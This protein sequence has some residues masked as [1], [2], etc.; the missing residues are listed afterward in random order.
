MELS[1]TSRSSDLGGSYGRRFQSSA[2]PSLPCGDA[3][4]SRL[5][6]PR[7]AE[8]LPPPARAPATSRQSPGLQRELSPPGMKPDL[9]QS[10]SVQRAAAPPAP[11]PRRDPAAPGA[12]P[13]RRTHPLA[14]GNGDPSKRVA[15]AAG[16]GRQSQTPVFVQRAPKFFPLAPRKVPFPR[17]PKPR[18]SS[19]R[20]WI[21]YKRRVLWGWFLEGE[22]TC[23]SSA[24]LEPAQVHL[25]SPH[26]ATCRAVTSSSPGPPAPTTGPGR[27]PHP[28]VGGSPRVTP[29]LHS[30]GRVVPAVPAPAPILRALGVLEGPPV[31]TAT[32]PA[33]ETGAVRPRHP[34]RGPAAPVPAAGGGA[35]GAGKGRSG[36][37]MEKEEQCRG[38][39]VGPEP[40]EDNVGVNPGAGGDRS[41]CRGRRAGA[42]ASASDGAGVSASDGAGGGRSVPVPG[43]KD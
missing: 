3:A 23:S 30:R 10:G 34:P 11:A 7:G 2:S 8:P 39:G 18:D 26:L 38:V 27:T 32:N 15:A 21:N 43:S 25:Q 14:L 16:P 28:S 41:L 36:P 22:G 37:V 29:A 19:E 24:P 35:R 17:E 12:A 20:F 5:P 13:G 33:G 6:A 1:L 9:I 42:G 31:P 40:G 4:R